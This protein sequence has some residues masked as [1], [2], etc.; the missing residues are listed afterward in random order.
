VWTDIAQRAAHRRLFVSDTI[1]DLLIRNLFEVFGEPDAERRREA[2]ATLWADDGVFADPHGR[3]VGHA[4]LN[5]AVSQLHAR[6]PG[7][8]FT[9]IGTPQAFH[10]VGRQAWGHGL[11]GEPPQVTG[12]D[13]VIV[14]E[15]RISA[16]YAFVDIPLTVAES[17]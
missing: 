3:H 1:P 15:N 4:A 8:I 10:G 14:Q 16:L 9:A 11:V 7:F 2:I 13:V 17:H 5:E 6:F 12:L